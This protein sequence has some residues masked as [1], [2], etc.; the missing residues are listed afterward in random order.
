MRLLPQAFVYLKL[1]NGTQIAL[2]SLIHFSF[3]VGY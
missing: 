3:I 2:I 1:T